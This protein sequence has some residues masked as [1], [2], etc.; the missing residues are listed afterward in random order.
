EELVDDDFH[1]SE[2]CANWIDL[3]NREN[4]FDNEEDNHLLEIEQN[5]YAI[6]RNIH[7]ADDKTAK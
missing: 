2:I 1:W 7:P 6:E 5:F 3:I 4:Q